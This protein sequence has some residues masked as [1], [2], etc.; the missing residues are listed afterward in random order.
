MKYHIDQGDVE[1]ESLPTEKMWA[2]VLNKPKHGK[3]FRNFIV[4]LINVQDRL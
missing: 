2:D 1:F 3:V 4:E